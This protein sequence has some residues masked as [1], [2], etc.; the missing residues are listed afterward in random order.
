ME[1]ME[2]IQHEDETSDW[3]IYAEYVMWRMGVDKAGVSQPKNEDRAC[4]DSQ[5]RG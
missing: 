2:Y 4:G 5:H 1:N 3:L